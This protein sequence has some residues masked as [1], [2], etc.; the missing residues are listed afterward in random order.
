[1]ALALIT[2]NGGMPPTKENPIRLRG[3]TDQQMEA[4]WTAFA[5]ICKEKYKYTH[6][7]ITAAVRVETGG[8]SPDNVMVKRAFR[9]PV[10]GNKSQ[11][12]RVFQGTEEAKIA[13]R[14]KLDEADKLLSRTEKTI[15]AVRKSNEAIGGFKGKMQDMKAQDALALAQ[16]TQALEGPVVPTPDSDE[17]K[18]K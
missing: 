14:A 13:V 12:A 5:V 2:A 9:E 1:M 17:L 4:L 18:Y 6:A 15:G 10:F 16:K 3:G 11:Y 8:F 7:Q